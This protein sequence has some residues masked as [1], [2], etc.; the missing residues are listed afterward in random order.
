VKVLVTGASGFLGGHLVEELVKRG[1]QVVALVRESSDTLFLDYLGVEMRR[2]DLTDPPSLER[3][4]RGV[5]AVI[6]L[7]AYYTFSGKR[8]QYQ[9]INVQG[10]RDLLEAMLA[11]HVRRLIY[12]SSTEAIGPTGEGDRKSVV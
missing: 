11:N 5:E 4:T 6:H 10:T 2:G 1:H 12:C 9:R 3:A 8:Q 7:A